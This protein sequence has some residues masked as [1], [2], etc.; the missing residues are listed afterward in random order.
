MDA[1]DVWK[2]NNFGVPNSTTLTKSAFYNKVRHLKERSATSE[3]RCGLVRVS[4][5]HHLTLSESSGCVRPSC[6]ACSGRLSR[7]PGWAGPKSVW[8][9]FGSSCFVYVERAGS[10]RGDSISW[11]TTPLPV[12]NWV[13]KYIPRTGGELFRKA[14]SGC[15]IAALTACTGTEYSPPHNAVPRTNP[16]GR[17]PPSWTRSSSAFSAAACPHACLLPPP[18]CS[19]ACPPRWTRSRPPWTSSSVASPP[20]L[21]TTGE[22]HRRSCFS[23]HGLIPGARVLTIRIFLLALVQHLFVFALARSLYPKCHA[24]GHTDK[25]A[26]NE[27]PLT[28]AQPS[29]VGSLLIIWFLSRIDSFRA[30]YAHFLRLHALL[31]D[32]RRK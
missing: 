24:C 28:P 13:I 16:N 17:F 3:R 18:C 23:V 26:A 4:L 31:G 30:K 1:G 10:S 19:C 8:V 21:W 27:S 22:P 7:L 20:D 6:S 29:L 15:S 2:S 9:V 32:H 25:Q 5:W 12:H 14:T 11:E